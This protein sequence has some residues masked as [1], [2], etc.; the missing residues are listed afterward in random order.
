MLVVSAGIILANL[1]VPSGKVLFSLGP[2]AVTQFALV[3]GILKALTFEGLMLISKASIMPGLRLPGRLGG[4]V[5]SAFLYYDRIIEYKGKVR[6]ASL[7]SDAD[8]MMRSVW[9]SESL[10]AGSSQARPGSG[11]RAETRRGDLT[12]AA[13]ALL[14]ALASI[15]I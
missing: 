5:A 1:L 12:L 14:V 4:I 9:E 8:A 6:A 7:A 15:F 10:E 2:F 3:D 13:L 11:L